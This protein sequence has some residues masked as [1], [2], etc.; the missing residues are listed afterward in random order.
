MT[1]YFDTSVL[2][3][4]YI[5]EEKSD[6]VQAMASDTC[7][8]CISQLTEV[9]FCSAVSR[10]VRMKEL[11]AKDGKKVISQFR[12]HIKQH[13]FNILPI[14]QKEYDTSTKWLGAFNTSLR[15]LDTIHLAA[16]FNNG[17]E[18]LTSDVQ[19]AESAKKL[20]VKVKVI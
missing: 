7:P 11:S 4:I 14:T 10:R 20:D 19:L 2:V 15:T 5:P 1:L 12:K 6:L 13:L 18:L 17:L 3:A 16:A 9:E 8:I